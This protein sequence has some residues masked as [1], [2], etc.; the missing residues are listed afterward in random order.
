MRE[1][2]PRIHGVFRVR[3]PLDGAHHLDSPVARFAQ[4]KIHLAQTNAVLASASVFQQQGSGR[5]LARR[6]VT[7]GKPFSPAGGFSRMANGK[8]RLLR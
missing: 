4:Q 7:C 3:R 5:Q 6:V 1:N 2:F 8:H